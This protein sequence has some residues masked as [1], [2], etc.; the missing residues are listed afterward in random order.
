MSKV[1]H[2]VD[3]F[4]KAMV[5]RA[6]TDVDSVCGFHFS[7][8]ELTRLAVT[9]RADERKRC[10]ADVCEGCR[11]HEDA[12]FVTNFG[13]KHDTLRYNRTCDAHTIRIR[14]AKESSK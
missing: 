4:W 7:R 3:E 9:V 13:W 14:D 1:D 8:S 6:Y 10:M 2:N 12:N 5:S 11:K